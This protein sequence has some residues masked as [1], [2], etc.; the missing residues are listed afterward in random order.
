[1]QVEIVFLFENNQGK[2][3]YAIFGDA[4]AKFRH[5]VKNVV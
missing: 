1:L 3:V 4:A 2:Q 5:G